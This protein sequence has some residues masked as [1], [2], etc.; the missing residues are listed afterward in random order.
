MAISVFA[1]PACA[2]NPASPEISHA[3]TDPDA[4]VSA[5]GTQRVEQIG[6]A[7]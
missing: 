7:S 4:I 5:T 1:A 6:R 2:V 3:C